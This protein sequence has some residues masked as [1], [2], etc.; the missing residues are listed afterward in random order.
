MIAIYESSSSIEE[1][2]RGLHDHCKSTVLRVN[3]LFVEIVNNM[4]VDAKIMHW[5][6]DTIK[7]FMTGT[8]HIHVSIVNDYDVPL[9]PEKSHLSEQIPITHVLPSLKNLK[10]VRFSADGLCNTPPSH[11][12][13]QALEN[14]IT[15][16]RLDVKLPYSSYDVKSPTALFINDLLTSILRS[17]LITELLLPNISRE[18]MAKVHAIIMQCPNLAHLELMRCRLGYDGMLYICNALRC[19]SSIKYIAIR[20]YKQD[21]VPETL[22]Y[23]PLKEVPNRATCTDIILS[24]NDILKENNTLKTFIISTGLFQLWTSDKLIKLVEY[25][26]FAQFNVRRI[27]NGTAPGLRRSYS[28]SDLT[29]LNTTVSHVVDDD[30][31]VRLS[32]RREMN[33][34]TFLR[35]RKEL[36]GMF[37][38][39]KA[40]LRQR[41]KQ[42][43][44]M[45]YNISF[46]APD[47]DIL[48]SFSHLDPRLMKCLGI[49]DLHLLAVQRKLILENEYH[50]NRLLNVPILNILSKTKKLSK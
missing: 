4:K 33:Q 2:C 17:K 41:K 28:L 34:N 45:C 15:K 42:R 35:Q 14:S 3:H 7:I 46:T 40:I 43:M 19:N 37:D 10:S 48:P 31:R 13:C 18:N 24:L 38:I 23:Y 1:F 6:A 25:E 22:S 44:K 11:P 29:P 21:I 47:T 39:R 5:L 49:T 8:K 36:I 26:P 12:I 16:L 9:N 32:I 27:R 20:D 30:E 50:N